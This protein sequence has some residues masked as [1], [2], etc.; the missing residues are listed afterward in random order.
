MKAMQPLPENWFDV[1]AGHF[2]G[3]RRVQGAIGRSC[4]ARRFGAQVEGL[5]GAGG[6]VWRGG[7][8]GLLK[9]VL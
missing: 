5:L 4:F 1:H 9:I 6:Q 2:E 7:S 3:R 8:R